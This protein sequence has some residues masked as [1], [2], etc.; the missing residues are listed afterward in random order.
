MKLRIV[1]IGG[2]PPG[3]VSAGFTEYA[4]RMPKDMP[5]TLEEVPAP[6]HGADPARSTR[7]EGEK[8]LSKVRDSDWA[9]A[10]DETGTVLTSTQLAT[11]MEHW[12]MQGRDVTFLIGGADGLAPDVRTRADEML[13]LSALTFP[14]Y[15]VRLILA[16]TLYRSWS[17]ASGHPYHRA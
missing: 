13:S 7:I 16:E 15:M 12:R 6:K 10:L 14:H 8:M 17:I 2:K 9:V 3:W 5:L 1:S 11:R 4:R